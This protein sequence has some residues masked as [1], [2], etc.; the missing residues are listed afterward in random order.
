MLKQRFII[1]ISLILLVIDQLLKYFFH[2]HPERVGVF[3]YYLNQNFSWSLPVANG[4]VI[5]V[6]VLLLSSLIYWRRKLFGP[7]L[8][9]YLI[10]TGAISNLI[11]RVARGGVVDYVFLPYGG[12]INLAD[13]IIIGGVILILCSRK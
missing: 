11:D 4:A 5:A 6:T 9:W 7:K 10:S 13:I 2:T 3:G 8:A 12:I 1:G